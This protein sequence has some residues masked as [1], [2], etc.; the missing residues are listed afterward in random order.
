[1][2]S[3][4]C[5]CR[6]I[7][8]IERVRT[9]DPK[10][11]TVHQQRSKVGN[12]SLHQFSCFSLA[13]ASQ[14]RLTMGEVI[15]NFFVD[16]TSLPHTTQG[17]VQLLFLGGTYAYILGYASNLISDGSELLLLV[18]SM[19]NLIGSVVLPILG[20]VPEGCMVLF[21]GLGPGAQGKR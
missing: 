19:A 7:V 5:L 10:P 12:F 20:A 9:G 18:P 11:E 15:N 3:E 16:V 13:E 6:K 21:S 8:R 4:C 17:F 14:N 1:M 2:V